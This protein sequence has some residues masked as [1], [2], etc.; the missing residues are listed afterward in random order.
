MLN[1]RI[2]V[3]T[4]ARALA[5]EVVAVIPDSAIILAVDGGIDHALAVGLRPSGLIGD[6]DSVS[7]DGM[8][9]AEAHATIARHPTDKDRTDTELALSF[10]AEM[11]PSG[12]TLVGGG[13]RLD[14]TL[15]ALGALGA[16][17]L[18]TVPD[19]DAWWDGQHVT[20]LHGPGQAELQLVPGSTLSLLALHG[21]CE[22]VE[23]T[24]VRWPLDGTRLE[25][26]VGLGIS[27]EVLSGPDPTDAT[28]PGTVRVQVSTGVLTMFD[29]PDR[30]ATPEPP[31]GR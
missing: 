13:D 26:M 16:I 9:W 14:H 20:V 6:L 18:T 22:R 27:N 15:G 12:I 1:E 8:A 4:G 17:D 25:P 29:V 23:L 24:G 31:E 5:P 30:T 10:A 3:I 11:L 2:V 19:I 7:A 21:P 28:P